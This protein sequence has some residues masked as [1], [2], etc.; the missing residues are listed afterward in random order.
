VLEGLEERHFHLIVD[1]LP[2]MLRPALLLGS[3]QSR[4]LWAIRRTV[5]ITVPSYAP[6]SHS[7]RRSSVVVSIKALSS[8]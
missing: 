6:L 3:A 1:Y 4:Y 8:L 5:A 2:V 7:P